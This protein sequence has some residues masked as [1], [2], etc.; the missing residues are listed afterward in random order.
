MPTSGFPLG[1]FINRFFPFIDP[2]D[3][4]GELPRGGM[5]G[6][7]GD[8]SGTIAGGNGASGRGYGAAGGGGGA[9]TNGA[10]SG[11]GANGNDGVVIVISVDYE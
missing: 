9:S 1:N 4:S 11:A 5:S 6:G 2:A 3:I 8:T 10:N 7:P